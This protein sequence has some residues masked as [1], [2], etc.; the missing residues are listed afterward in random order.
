MAQ[1]LVPYLLSGERE[2]EREECT[3]LSFIIYS[4]SHCF[5]G[6][7]MVEKRCVTMYK[8]KH[9]SWNCFFHTLSCCCCCCYSCS[10]QRKAFF[11]RK[12]ASAIFLFSYSFEGK[13]TLSLS[14]RWERWK[15]LDFWIHFY[16]CMVEFFYFVNTVAE[17]IFLR[18]I[19]F[20]DGFWLNC[21]AEIWALIFWLL[22]FWLIFFCFWGFI[23]FGGVDE[24]SQYWCGSV[25]IYIYVLF[26]V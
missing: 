15:S 24:I 4:F 16:H 19:V 25:K 12:A 1:S 7:R 2:R 21:C 20:V 8:K 11:N 14:G 26:V 22:G 23:F 5:F 18:V 9:I 17:I 10:D 6:W 13:L 3:F